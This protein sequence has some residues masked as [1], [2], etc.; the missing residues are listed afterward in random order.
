M[1]LREKAKEAKRERIHAAARRL[2]SSRGFAATT[3]EQIARAARV[4]TGTVFLY[5]PDKGALLAQVFCGEVA[6]I[7]GNALR[8]VDPRGPFAAQLLGLFSAFYAYY[9]KDVAL[10]RVFLKEL[11]FSSER[12]PEVAAATRAF[13]GAIAVLAEAARRRGELA[14]DASPMRVASIVFAVYWACLV[15]WLG[16]ALPSKE[17]ALGEL[18]QALKL[19]MAGIA[20]KG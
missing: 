18:A 20:A 11:L 8:E 5:A 12:A 6:R 16:G 15:A 10:S 14:S 9:E 4:A 7:Q 13:V 1:S 19:V 2:F 17:A 3:I